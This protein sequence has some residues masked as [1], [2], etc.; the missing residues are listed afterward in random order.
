MEDRHIASKSIET[1]LLEDRLE[2]ADSMLITYDELSALIGRDVRKQGYPSLCSARRILLNRGSNF[3]T[4]VG[5]GIR[6][7]TPR[8]CLDDATKARKHLGR[9][10]RTAKKKLFSMGEDGYKGLSEQE[11]LRHNVEASILAIVGEASKTSTRKKI[12][13]RASTQGQLP[14]EEALK[15]LM[16]K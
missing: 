14:T 8:D 12:E 1:Q 3:V 15:A 6:R 10:V 11:Q 13:A 7:A 2:A 4:V 9:A 16:D 5:K